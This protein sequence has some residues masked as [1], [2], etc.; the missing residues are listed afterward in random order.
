MEIDSC[1]YLGEPG[2]ANEDPGLWTDL[3]VRRSESSAWLIPG[4]A[5]GRAGDAPAIAAQLSR[6]WER[7]LRYNYR[8]VHTVVSAP[9]SVTLCAVTQVAS[10]AFWVAIRVR[11]NL[12]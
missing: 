3:I 5:K 9:D 4:S 7:R 6:I 8:S 11:V 12:I 2:C 1:A 10:H